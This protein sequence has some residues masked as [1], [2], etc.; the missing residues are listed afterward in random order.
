VAREAQ[1]RLFRRLVSH[2]LAR[3]VPAELAALAA[4]L[5]PPAEVV[6][7][8]IAPRAARPPRPLPVR[9]THRAGA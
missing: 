3:A 7:V 9:Y 1:Q 6:A 5:R 2:R 4:E 8:T